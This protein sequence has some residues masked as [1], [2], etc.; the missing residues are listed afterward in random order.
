[1]IWASTAVLTAE[2]RNAY[3]DI[4][5]AIRAQ[6]WLGAATKLD[7]MPEGPLHAAA[8]EEIYLA[9]GSPRVELEPLVALLAKAPDLPK[10]DQ[11]SRRAITRGA[12][13]LPALPQP[14]AMI[15]Q[16]SQPRRARAQSAPRDAV[17][18]AV[19]AQLTPLIN[20]NKPADAE[21][22]FLARIN[23]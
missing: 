3:R 10:A 6:D 13:S 18:S 17:S 8:R 4:F 19:A 20:D 15:F 5:A 14:R 22:A 1:M 9:K 23:E 11:L 2:Q 7:A 12:A 16:G 21:A